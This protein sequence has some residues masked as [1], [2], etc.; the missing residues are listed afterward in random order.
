MQRAYMPDSNN[1]DHLHAVVVVMAAE[2]YLKKI[3]ESGYSKY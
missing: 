3:V 2:D 1:P